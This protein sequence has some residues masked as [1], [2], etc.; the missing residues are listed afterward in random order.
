[1]QTSMFTLLHHTLSYK[2]K[3]CGQQEPVSFPLFLWLMIRIVLLSTF[4]YF[5]GDCLWK[6]D[7]YVL[8]PVISTIFSQ[9]AVLA[10]DSSALDIDQVENLI[11][12]CPTKEE[13]ET[14]KVC[15]FSLYLLLS[16]TH[17]HTHAP[18]YMHSHMCLWAAITNQV[19]L[20]LSPC[21]ACSFCISPFLWRVLPCLKCHWWYKE[22]SEFLLLVPSR[23]YIFS[24]IFF[25]SVDKILQ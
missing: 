9:N 18:P 17:M 2:K 15:I 8:V 21:L 19:V 5:K 22:L 25:S 20:M 6:V 24:S 16:H 11:K 23:Q 1:M 10:L 14:L 4:I 7:S 3:T 12:F 13:M